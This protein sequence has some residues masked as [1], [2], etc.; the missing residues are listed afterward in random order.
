MKKLFCSFFALFTLSAYAQINQG[1]LLTKNNYF[2]IPVTETA[3]EIHTKATIRGDEYDFMLDTG[4]PAFISTELQKKY[5]FA[6][7]YKG[8]TQD[9]SGNKVKTEIVLIDTIQFGPF[10]LTGIPAIVIDMTESPLECLN[11]PGNIG[12]NML[13]HLYVQFDLNEQR[14][15]I[16]DDKKLFKKQTTAQHPM[17][18]SSQ[19]DVYFTVTLNGNIIDTI[20]Y[21]SGD[22]QLYNISKR[23]MN[24]YISTYPDHVIRSGYGTMF[25][26]MGGAGSPFPQYIVRSESIKVG[27]TTINT[28]T[29][30]IAGNDKSR[31]GR[32]MLDYG[33]FQL[34][35]PDSSYAFDP[36]PTTNIPT[37]FDFG[38]QSV[39]NDDEVTIGCVW[40]KTAAEKQGLQ[41]GDR[42]LK[43]DD[44]D[45]TTMTKCE[46]VE[47]IRQ[48]SK[49]EKSTINLTFRHKKQKPQTI[50]VEKKPL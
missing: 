4:A 50:T 7:L 2:E 29:I 14:V 24:K 41:S 16:T 42:I 43:V 23:T 18:V 35:Y 21:D 15:A 34:N 44:M 47:A 12:S 27:S 22:A 31:M 46:A 38:F 8:K 5:K 10:V 3:K 40:K 48:V 11:L 37:R 6:H 17:V 20:H 32:R 49:I 30:S 26:G 39:M 9:A 33:L 25:M 19:S 36:Y 1:K 13:R 45:F 28:G